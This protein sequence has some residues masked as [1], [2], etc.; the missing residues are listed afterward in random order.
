MKS[1]GASF[2][3]KKMMGG[4]TFMV[5]NKMCVGIVKDKFMARIN[6]DDYNEALLKDGCEPMTFTGKEMKGYLF[7]RDEGLDRD[8]QLDYW[9][10]QCLAYNPLANSSK[11]KK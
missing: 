8:E 2:E 5:D 4:L 7:I 1:K 9:V 6:P 10:A 11:K 3:E